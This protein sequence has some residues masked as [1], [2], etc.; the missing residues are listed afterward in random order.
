MLLYI[1]LIMTR[2]FSYDAMRLNS[3]LYVLGGQALEMFNSFSLSDVASLTRQSSP[4]PHSTPE[5]HGP[6]SASLF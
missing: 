3:S 4:Q 2:W 1:T 5:L 6:E